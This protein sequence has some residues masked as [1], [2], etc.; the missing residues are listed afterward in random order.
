MRAA[1]VDGPLQ[2]NALIDEV[3]SASEGASVA[4]VGRVRDVNDGHTVSGLDYTAYRPMAER[5]LNDVVREAETRWPGAR[6]ICEHRIGA[7]RPGDASV[8]VV[9]SHPHRADAFDA[10]RYVIE[11]IKVRVPIWKRE[12]YLDRD[13]AWVA[14]H[15]P[16]ATAGRA[17]PDSGVTR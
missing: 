13:P 1:I 9:A 11:Q 12:H 4:F 10:C 17:V 2:A 15:A 3:S 5:E 7:L 8:V 14:A 16:G 6:V